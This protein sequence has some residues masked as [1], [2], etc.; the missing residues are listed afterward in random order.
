MR[1]GLSL[2]VSQSQPRN[3]HSVIDKEDS[4]PG[5]LLMYANYSSVDETRRAQERIE[6]WLDMNAAHL[7]MERKDMNRLFRNR[8]V[9]TML[10]LGTLVLASGC[11]IDT[12]TIT[13]LDILNTILLGIT[14]AGSI[15]LIR[16]V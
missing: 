9:T 11:E 8:L 13:G 4:I 6:Y 16:A 15:V 1:V 10:A 2:V 5:A 3:L 14:A 7:D 12:S